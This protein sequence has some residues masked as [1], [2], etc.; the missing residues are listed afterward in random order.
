MRHFIAVAEELHFGRAARRLN[1]AQPP[2]SQS[3]KRL[4]A[5]LGVELFIRAKGGVGVTMTEAGR[6]FL[7]EAKR[8]LMQAELA[9]KTAQRAAAGIADVRICFVGPALYRILP[10]LILKFHE[11][12][13]AID[14]QLFE[15]ASPEQIAGIHAG[16][17]DIGFMIAGTTRTDGM[18]TFVVQ[19]NHHMAAVPANWPLARKTSVS[20]RE[21]EGLPFIRPPKKFLQQSSKLLFSDTASFAPRVTQEAAQINTTISLVGAGLGCSIVTGAAAA[22]KPRNVKFLPIRDYPSKE[23]AELIMAWLPDHDN[24]SASSFVKAAKDYVAANP[25]LLDDTN[26]LCQTARAKRRR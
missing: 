18:D 22:T 5:F 3:I 1:M 11:V 21:L 4:E 24:K 16:E 14:I 2:V 8:T 9:C 6:A 12:H 13:P 25:S 7:A 17:F 20:L 15:R 23:R 26:E 10:E 19:R